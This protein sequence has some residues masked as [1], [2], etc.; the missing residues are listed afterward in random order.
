[1]V[2]YA[3]PRIGAE[4]AAQSGSKCGAEVRPQNR[5]WCGAVLHPILVCGCNT[6]LYIPNSSNDVLKEL[7][8]GSIL[9][10]YLEREYFFHL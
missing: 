2:H 6:N 1:V 8:S 3:H 4:S 10:G 7:F 9:H 5:T